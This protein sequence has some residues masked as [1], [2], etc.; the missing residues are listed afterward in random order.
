MTIK[1]KVKEF[2]RIFKY[3][4]SYLLT[5]LLLIM[6]IVNFLY[7]FRQIGPGKIPP[8]KRIPPRPHPPPCDNSND[9]GLGFD[10]HLELQTPIAPRSSMSAK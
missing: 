9:S 5:N 8:G 6:N 1:R 4:D 10:Q 7:F 2:I 3:I